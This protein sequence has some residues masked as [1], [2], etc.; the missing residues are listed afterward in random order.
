[1]GELSMLE[2]LGLQPLGL[3]LREARFALAGDAYTPKSRFDHT[4]LRI[5]EPRLALALW[6]GRRPTGRSRC[7]G[8]AR[9][10]PSARVG[11]T[12]RRVPVAFAD[13]VEFWRNNAS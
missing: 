4:S 10:S 8:V 12:P 9:R 2:I 13:V 1:M 3:R 11:W 6:R 7:G 5:L